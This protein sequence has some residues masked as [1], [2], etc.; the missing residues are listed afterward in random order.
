MVLKILKPVTPGIRNYVK[1]VKKNVN[2][3]PIIK[4]KIKKIKHYFGKNNSGK[5]VVRYKCRGHKKLYRILNFTNRSYLGIVFTI[6]YDPFRNA[7][8]ASIYDI[9]KN[10]FFYIISPKNLVVGN[11]IKAGF[12]GE[13][14]LGHVL[15]LRKIPIGCCIHNISFKP[16]NSAKIS[17]AAGTYS[18]ITKKTK[19]YAELVLSSGSKINLNLNCFA[20]IGIVSNE[21]FFLTQRGKAGRSYWLGN[22]PKVRGV[23]MNPVDHPNGGGEG[24]KSGNRITP[25]GKP[26]CSKN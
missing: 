4:S 14:K 8:I 1:L 19:N 13:Q 23:A 25:W 3:N 21:L 15:N 12:Y 20:S 5:I 6:E 24:K 16:N 18:I 26:I 22:R 7:N 11:I 9:K 17:R 2:K 10:T